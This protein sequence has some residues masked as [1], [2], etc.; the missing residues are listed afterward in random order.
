MTRD[1]GRHTKR[2]GFIEA[3]RSKENLVGD[4]NEKD[5]GERKK[6]ESKKLPQNQKRGETITVKQGR[7]WD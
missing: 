2:T 1:Q 7:D 3:V 5:G 6:T 4:P